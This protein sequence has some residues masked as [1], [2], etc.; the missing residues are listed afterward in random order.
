MPA[1]GFEDGRGGMVAGDHHHVRAQVQ[2]TGDFLVDLL[3]QLDLAVEIAVL[4]GT[5]GP[6]DMQK[7]EI[8][9]VESTAISVPNPWRFLSSL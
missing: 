2:H 1:V 3:D 6:F 8:K 9:P 7:K 5:V 4:T